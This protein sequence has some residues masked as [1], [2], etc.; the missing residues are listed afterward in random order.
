MER[1]PGGEA[2]MPGDKHCFFDALPFLLRSLHDTRR[3]P[4]DAPAHESNDAVVEV[5]GLVRGRQPL[6]WVPPIETHKYDKIWMEEAYFVCLTLYSVSSFCIE[7]RLLPNFILLH[8]Y[9]ALFS[10]RCFECYSTQ[11][12]HFYFEI[13]KNESKAPAW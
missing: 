10:Y 8:Q 3:A 4:R 9:W 13:H 7:N 6:M 11:F 12:C 5:A 1:D 2:G